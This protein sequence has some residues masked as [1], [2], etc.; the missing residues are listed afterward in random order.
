MS[1]RWRWP[2]WLGPAFSLRSLLLAITFVACVAA[3]PQKIPP[4][5]FQFKKTGKFSDVKV[6][7]DGE[8]IACAQSDVPVV[9]VFDA[10]TGEQKLSARGAD[11]TRTT[12][13]K[14]ILPNSVNFGSDGTVV[15]LIY[16]PWMSVWDLSTGKI[17]G[18][19]RATG[20]FESASLKPFES[21]FNL[22]EHWEPAYRM[23]QCPAMARSRFPAR[24]SRNG[25]VMAFVTRDGIEVWRPANRLRWVTQCSILSVAF[26]AALIVSLTFDQRRRRLTQQ[27]PAAVT[28]VA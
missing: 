8:R 3:I 23:Q 27:S 26:A 1:P 11:E 18:D 12:L 22:V 19:D 25:Q 4:W 20:L 17:V 24:L 13:E 28:V 5:E 16:R 7:T 9:R 21:D 10:R 14:G 2:A 6:S 15:A